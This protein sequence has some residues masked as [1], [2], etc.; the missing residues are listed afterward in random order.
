MVSTLKEPHEITTRKDHQ[1]QGCGAKLPK[2]ATAISSAYADGGSAWTF[3]ECQECAEYRQRE[4][5][6]CKDRWI[7]I[8]V[9]YNV[10]LIAECR[11]ESKR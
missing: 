3:Y 7:C 8:E 6:K 5:G 1:C 11:R 2:G 4:C 10:G 9:N